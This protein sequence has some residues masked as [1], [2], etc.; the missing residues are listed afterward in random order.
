MKRTTYAIVCIIIITVASI[1][2]HKWI[3]RSM[4]TVHM[5][6]IIRES[7]RSVASQMTVIEAYSK[8]GRD[9]FIKEVNKQI[10]IKLKQQG[11]KR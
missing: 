11:G 4:T 3:L 8:G 1:I 9:K 6:D 2:A 5:E 7:I 10:E